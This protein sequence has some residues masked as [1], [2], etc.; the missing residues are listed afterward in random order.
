MLEYLLKSA[1]CM[2]ILL[3]FYKVFLEKEN[4]HVFKRFYLLAALML[5][6]TIPVLIVNEQIVEVS[7]QSQISTETLQVTQNLGPKTESP[8]DSES[9][10]FELLLSVLY[11]AG[12]LIF[13][14]RFFRQ[15]MPIIF[16]IRRNPRVK[17]KFNEKVLLGTKMP[18]HTFFKYIF[19]NLREYHANSIPKEIVLHE[20]IHARQRHSYDVFLME[21]LQVMF[22]FNPLLYFFKK[23]IQLNHEFLA[24][25]GVLKETSSTLKYQNLML[26]YLSQ[27]SPYNHQSVSMASAMNYS[28]IKKRFLVM[29]KRTSNKLKIAKGMLAIPLMVFLLFSFGETKMVPSVIRTELGV[30]LQKS[31]VSIIIDNGEII[32]NNREV[33]L[34][35]FVKELNALSKNWEETD[36]TSL[37]PN[38]HIRNTSDKR[39]KEIDREF[40]KSHISKANGG[41][42]IIP[43]KP[44]VPPA[45]PVP[46]KEARNQASA[47]S[48]KAS[49]TEKPVLPPA[50]PKPMDPIDHVI[51]MAKR[52][53]T[54]YN[55]GKEISSDK[56]IELLKK[57]KSLNISTTKSRSRNPQ[58]KISKSPIR[59]NRSSTSKT[60]LE[61]GNITVNGNELFYSTK[62]GITSYFNV[63]GEQVNRQ[64]EKL[65]EQLKKNPVFYFNG[66]KISSAKAHQLLKNNKSI[67]VTNEDYT[68]DQYAIILTD[69]NQV[70][71]NRNTNKN[72]NPNSIIDLTEMIEKEAS[73][74]YNDQ[75]IS[76][77]K[78]LWLTKNIDIER[79]N[80][81][82]TKNGK[83][84]VYFWK[85]V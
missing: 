16:R 85:K 67:Q 53:A 28:S 74:F 46:D 19:L 56:A 41:M 44:P 18:P 76:I 26:S 71:Y 33:A 39:L 45:P 34:K 17:E 30:N 82:G 47:N 25:N 57:N 81:K 84:K 38:I 68:G 83:P 77:E 73:F 72:N 1:A 75:P 29:K 61:T 8:T 5:S 55:E 4:M 11:G 63:K 36:Y 51:E 79:V 32:L 80:T 43:P 12:V 48:P 24:D 22:W 37:R 27:E 31:G 13:A 78:A 42:S 52:G 14:I 10:N 62:N 64:G 40:K 15:L 69:L 54:F 50:P 35:D 70:S 3:L 23:S 2:G 58:V 65:E 7:S 21:L 49:L 6:F 20:E 66:D 9:F 59:I 60:N